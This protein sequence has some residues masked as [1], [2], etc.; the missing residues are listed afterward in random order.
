MGVALSIYYAEPVYRE[1]EAEYL[2]TGGEYSKHFEKGTVAYLIWRGES[3]RRGWN[4]WNN[5]PSKGRCRSNAVN[6]RFTA[7]TIGQIKTMQRRAGSPGGVFAVGMP[8]LIPDTMNTCTR[9]LGIRD[10]ELF[11]ERLQVRLLADCLTRSPKRAF[12]HR[13]IAGNGSIERAGVDVALEWASI[14]SPSYFKFDGRACHVNRGCYDGYGVNHAGIK[15]SHMQAAL[16][17]A[18]DAYAREMAQGTP[19]RIAYVRALGI[20][21]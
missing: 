11:D 16:R 12:I 14:S 15:A 3:K 9:Q 1:A 18:R 21:I 13:A 19:E 5:C 4:D 20:K 7:M 8:Q 6:H 17:L 10:S 2:Y